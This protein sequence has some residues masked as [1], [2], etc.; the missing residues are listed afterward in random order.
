[1]KT[2]KYWRKALL[3]FLNYVYSLS[4]FPFFSMIL[5]RYSHLFHPLNS[6]ETVWKIT[7][8]FSLLVR[9]PLNVPTLGKK[10]N[11]TKNQ[12][13]LWNV[14]LYLF[15]ENGII[16]IQ[17]TYLKKKKLSYFLRAVLGPYNKWFNKCMYVCV[18]ICICVC[19]HTHTH[20]FTHS[21][22]WHSFM[23]TQVGLLRDTAGDFFVFHFEML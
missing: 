5:I 16:D 4:A 13:K 12:I 23:D 14:L 3:C 10:Y 20:I 2:L 21:L 6:I 11:N 19:A 15:S 9:T 22:A 1:M 8:E 18:C 17:R 7:T